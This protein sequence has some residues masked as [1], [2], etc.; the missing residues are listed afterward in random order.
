MDDDS[1]RNRRIL[2]HR[3]QAVNSYAVRYGREQAKQMMEGGFRK[4]IKELPSDVLEAAASRQRLKQLKSGGLDVSDFM[5]TVWRKSEATEA[6]KRVFHLDSRI[7][8]RQ[9][10]RVV[11]YPHRLKKTVAGQIA[12]GLATAAAIEQLAKKHESE[13]AE[14]SAKA[15]ACGLEVTEFACAQLDAAWFFARQS[16][17]QL[18]IEP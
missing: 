18:R 7:F 10:R 13:I 12:I 6:M 16:V 2:E 4:A 14:M 15:K 9:D 1:T 5:Q 8:M 17:P 11:F 3:F